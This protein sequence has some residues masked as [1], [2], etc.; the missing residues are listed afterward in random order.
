MSTIAPQIVSF[1]KAS[2]AAADLFE[3]ID[4]ESEID[5]LS[6]SGHVPATCDGVI[7][8][9]GIKFVYP[10]RPDVTILH[11]FTLSVPAHKTT[12]LVGASGSGKST[13]I[14]LLGQ[15]RCPLQCRFSDTSQNAGMT[16]HM[17]RST[18]TASTFGN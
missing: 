2:S 10:A 7:E 1:T 11:N 17:E 18:L 6:D 5:S 15:L 16:S 9:E 13:I 12:A 8:I 4:R 3:T 14:G